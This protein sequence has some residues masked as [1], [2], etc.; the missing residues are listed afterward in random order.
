MAM[1]LALPMT[2]VLADAEPPSPRHFQLTLSAESRPSQPSGSD[3]QPKLVHL[4]KTVRLRFKVGANE[5][6]VHEVVTAG[7]AFQSRSERSSM[8]AESHLTLSGEV[9]PEGEARKVRVHF[10]ISTNHLDKVDG[11]RR[12]GQL[13][14]SALMDADKPLLLG[15]LAGDAITL[16]LKFE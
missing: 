15:A 13:S 10:L 12:M 1:F 11:S 2:L 9:L 6:A 3:K 7:G 5:S 4:G 16:T 14:G 8:D